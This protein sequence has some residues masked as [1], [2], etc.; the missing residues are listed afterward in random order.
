M[1]CSQSVVY[2]V[3]T[4]SASGSQPFSFRKVIWIEG[5]ANSGPQKRIHLERAAS[6]MKALTLKEINSPL[7]LED[8]P[9]LTPASNEV[10]VQ[11][12]A[13][14]LNRRDYWITK[15]MYPGIQPPVVLGSDGAGVVSQT[16][17]ELGNFWQGPRSDYQPQD[18][19]GAITRPCRRTSSQSLAC[20]VME[21]SPPRSPFLRH[22]FTRSLP[23]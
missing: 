23:I 16:G 1:L 18:S 21:H 7:V 3:S 12:R 15:G 14:A 17:S 10:V 20:P 19:T 9:S 4:R 2:C 11:L 5:A 22:S 13:A 6:D 8:R